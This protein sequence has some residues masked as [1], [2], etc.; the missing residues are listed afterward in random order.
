[1]S[2]TDRTA[3]T[4]TAT[5]RRAFLRVRAGDV[6][7]TVRPQGAGDGAA[8]AAEARVLDVSRGGLRLALAPAVAAGLAAGAKLAVAHPSMGEI[9]GTCLR[10]GPE[11]EVALAFDPTA[12]EVERALQCLALLM[13]E[14]ARGE[15]R[16]QGAS[17]QA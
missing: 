3:R 12:N 6:V 2:E 14:E 1:M 10:H 13:A 4:G 5:D 16:Q 8:G 17:G 15:A 9:G 11:G 7:V